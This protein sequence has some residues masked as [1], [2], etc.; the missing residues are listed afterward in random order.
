MGSYTVVI[1]P[2][3]VRDGSG[4]GGAQL[5]IEVD[6]TAQEAQVTEVAIKATASAGL[7]SQ[8]LLGIDIA[9]IVTALAARFAPHASTPV[10]PVDGAGALAP[11]L[12]EPDGTLGLLFSGHEV[13]AVRPALSAGTTG[14]S[15]R[16]YRRMPE[17]S[18]LRAMYEQLGTVTGVAKHYRVPRHT[19]QGWMG[20][21][22]KLDQPSEAGSTTEIVVGTDR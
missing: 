4:S 9:K 18:E 12:P 3:S 17:I 16:A 13:R 22:R 10:S 11:S 19:A 15:G 2:A 20:R 8:S 21:L 14:G 7:T 6:T 5:T 1:T